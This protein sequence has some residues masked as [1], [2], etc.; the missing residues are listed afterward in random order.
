VAVSLEIA[1]RASWSKLISCRGTDT[2]PP[3]LSCDDATLNQQFAVSGEKAFA[4]ISLT[5]DRTV[6]QPNDT[7]VWFTANDCEF[8]K[9]FVKRNEDASFGP[10][11]GKDC[12]ISWVSRPVANPSNVVARSTK[13]FSRLPRQATV[14]KYLHGAE[15][16]G[17]G[18]Q[19][20]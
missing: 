15:A 8:T 20:S 2:Q 18:S 7:A 16:M 19:R 1:S 17:N 4:S 9:V 13:H 3:R 12:C 14:E 11:T 5:S 10:C 6:H